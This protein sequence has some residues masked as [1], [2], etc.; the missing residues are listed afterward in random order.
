[1]D[2]RRIPRL[3]RNNPTPEELALWQ[4]IS[5]LRPRFTRQLKIH[6]HVADFSCRAAR[7]IVEV[8]GSQHVDNQGD[9]ERTADLEARGWHVIRLWNDEVRENLDGVVQA[10]MIA[11]DA[12]LPP[13]KRFVFEP[14]HASRE[15]RPRT[16]KKE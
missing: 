9:I 14:S 5:R 7:L 1:M 8:D 6:P 10:I 2:P 13:G 12:R 4:A 11:G 16:R 3:L 15:R